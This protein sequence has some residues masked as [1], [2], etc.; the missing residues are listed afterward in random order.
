MIRQANISGDRGFEQYRSVHS[1]DIRLTVGGNLFGVRK[2]STNDKPIEYAT[3]SETRDRLYK[4][5]TNYLQ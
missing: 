4:A 2:P 3:R 1:V 5:F